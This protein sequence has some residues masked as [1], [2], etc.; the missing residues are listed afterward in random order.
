MVVESLGELK[1][2][3]RGWRSKKRYTR[4]SV[5]EE[6]LDRARRA[7]AVHGLAA[8]VKA[9]QFDRSR[10]AGG[11]KAGV[12]ARKV[13]VPTVPPYSRLELA[14]PIS[15]SRPLAEAETQSGMKLRIFQ[16]TPE[17]LSLLT[18]MCGAGGAP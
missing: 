1:A 9:T 7:V 12:K 15:A 11:G 3:F 17:T 13:S 14:S 8:V 4:E 16:I 10:L 6:L 18:V 2:A 5:P